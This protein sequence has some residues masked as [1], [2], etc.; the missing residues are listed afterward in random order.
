MDKKYVFPK[1]ELKKQPRTNFDLSFP[2]RTSFA[3][4][5][6]IPIMDIESMPTDSFIVKMQALIQ[7]LPMNAP[8]MG[9]WK[10]R[11]LFFENP[12]S[13]MYGWMDNNN[14]LTTEEW[15]D[16]DCHCFSMPYP[17]SYNTVPQSAQMTIRPVRQSSLFN[18]LGLPVGFVGN[19]W[20]G[21]EGT[22]Q[23]RDREAN[24]FNAEG[25]L[26]YLD[27]VRNYLVNNQENRVPFVMASSN[28]WYNVDDLKPVVKYYS[29]RVLDNLFM[30]LRSC[31]QGAYDI[32]DFESWNNLRIEDDGEY[33]ELID[34]LADLTY[35]YSVPFGGLACVPYLMDFNRGIMNSS[36]GSVEARVTVDS[37]NFTFAVPQLQFKNKMQNFVN[38]LD[39]SG[40]RFGDVLSVVWQSN[41]KG[42]V[43]RPIFVGSRSEWIYMTD[44]VATAT[45]GSAD[46]ADEKAYSTAGEQVGFVSGRTRRDKR[47]VCNFKFNEYGRFMCIFQLMP[48]V[49]YSAGIDLQLYKR[50]FSDKYTPQYAQVGY[51]DVSN[52]ELSSLPVGDTK[53]GVVQPHS[54]S[55]GYSQKVGTRIAWSEYT[56]RYP[57]VYGEFA[58]GGKFDYWVLLR[59]YRYKDAID[60]SS[61]PETD[62]TGFY[63]LTFTTYAMPFLFNYL[64]VEQDLTAQN[65]RLQVYFDIKAKRPLPRRAMPRL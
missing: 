3:P 5:L 60:F 10:A 6:S 4:C 52:H 17:S 7:S 20:V 58:Q 12:L 53:F 24:R 51:Q 18:Y 26:T 65:F 64:F 42:G 22:L 45:T 57:K 32:F 28:Y 1:V 37:D 55:N 38:L 59:R 8:A 19:G 41:L 33:Q 23:L 16:R 36:V 61:E 48:E 2:V 47:A 21:E 54:G 29:L 44:I 25:L 13:N 62:V 15:M 39:L 14:K 50:S 49:S 27:I 56:C 34:F 30:C 46:D 43:D 31:K 9:R 11:F 35:S 63:D 40:G